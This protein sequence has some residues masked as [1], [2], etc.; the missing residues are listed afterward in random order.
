M[1]GA[2]RREL[3]VFNFGHHYLPGGKK[4]NAMLPPQVISVF[5]V[6]VMHHFLKPLNFHCFNTLD[7]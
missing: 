1:H 4:G 7:F 3:M 5:P 2:L 6:I